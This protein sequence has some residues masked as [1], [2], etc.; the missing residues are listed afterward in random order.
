MN[1]SIIAMKNSTIGLVSQMISIVLQFVTRSI[2]IKYLGVEMLGLSSTFAS[3]LGALSV[4]ELGFQTA[5]T[6]HLYK[7]IVENDQK[8]INDIINIYKLVYRCIGVF[9][10]VASF[11]CVPLL[12]FIV[13]G[14]EVT[15]Y[16]RIIFLVQA[17]GSAC[18][19]FL[20][21]KRSLLYADQKAYVST[22][23]DMCINIIANVLQIVAVI[24]T[25]NYLLYLIIKVV[26]VYISNVAVHIVCARRYPYLH[27]AT[28]NK[29]ML[30]RIL[31]HVK[32]VFSSR[33]S[34]Y[35]YTSTDSLVI[36]AIV[37]TIQVGFFN[38][39]TI[40]TN[41]IKIVA[42]SITTPIAPI[43][44]NLIVAEDDENQINVFNLYNFIRFII[45][46][47][48]VLPILVLA[49]EFVSIWVGEEYI[50]SNSI[51]ALLCAD[52]Y[53]H[54]MH[55]SCCD[56]IYGNGLFKI[57]KYI[58]IFGAV[59]NLSTSIIFVM[60]FGIVGVLIGT[61]SSQMFFWISRSAI[62]FKVCFNKNMKDYMYYWIKQIGY[63]ALFCAIYAIQVSVISKICEMFN[64]VIS[65]VVSGSLCE[66][67]FII[68][69]C[70]V[71]LGFNENKK[72]RELIVKM[73]KNKYTYN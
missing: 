20:A 22:T 38:N 27:K 56:Y 62:T 57:D 13:K 19:Y 40:I 9:F 25:R 12:P 54:I 68:I 69:S 53:I 66:I 60:K 67:L 29:E 18:T 55:T 58:S 3:V 39:Y 52:L 70:I 10:I 7:P 14:I 61:V 32:D 47:V 17:A 6:Y 31:A 30:K 28:I 15:N 34:N 5:V 1:R 64:P 4:A 11:V 50:L 26:Q 41:N 16:I 23:I 46:G 45:C 72:C 48:L 42:N 65:F 37:G 44:G 35:V 63:L 33:I 71:T 8:T 2:F 36:S 21:Y 24:F 51:L 59:L 73:L 43:I 49:H